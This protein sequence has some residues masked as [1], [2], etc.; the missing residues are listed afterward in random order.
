MNAA[1][2][3]PGSIG[4][5]VSVF[6]AANP[7]EFLTV[8]DICVK[9]DSTANAVTKAILDARANGLVSIDT[10]IDGTGRLN[11][12]GPGPALLKMIGLLV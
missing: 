3:T 4:F 9:T 1:R 6:F 10:Q 12:Y 7:E 2:N 5:V 11:L 8:D